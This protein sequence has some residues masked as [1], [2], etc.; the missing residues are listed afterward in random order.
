MYD[1]SRFSQKERATEL[2]GK[3]QIE[4]V[5]SIGTGPHTP[6]AVRVSGSHSLAPELWIMMQLPVATMQH[7]RNGTKHYFA[8]MDLPKKLFSKYKMHNGVEIDEVSHK[9]T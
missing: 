8:V 6:V 3:V 5:S 9:F 1:T 7:K 4:A 2:P